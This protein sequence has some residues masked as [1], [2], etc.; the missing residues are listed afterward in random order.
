MKKITTGTR[1]LDEMLEI[2]VKSHI[3]GGGNSYL[4]AIWARR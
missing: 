3:G 2:A 1:R 4:T